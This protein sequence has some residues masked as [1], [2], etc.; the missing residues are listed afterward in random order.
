M[1]LYMVAGEVSGD[2]RGAELMEALRKQSADIEFFGAGGPRMRAMAGNHFQDWSE[3]AVVGIIDVIKNYGYFKK[4]FDGM[5]AEIMRL[6]PDG[7]VFIDYPG[8]NLRLAAAIKKK[9]PE[10][11]CHVLY[12]SAGMGMEP[13]QDSENGAH[14]RFDDL[15]FPIRKG[16]L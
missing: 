6:N 5:L 15:H 9:R 16:A 3:H 4:Q 11:T 7:V 13:G 8:F 10:V 14:H 2:G 12:Q 1:K